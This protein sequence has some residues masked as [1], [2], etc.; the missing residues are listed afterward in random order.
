MGLFVCWGLSVHARTLGTHVS[1]CV[2]ASLCVYAGV[3]QYL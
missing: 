2:L 1:L 3:F